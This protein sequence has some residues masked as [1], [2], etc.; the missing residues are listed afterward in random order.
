MN[1]NYADPSIASGHYQY[2]EKDIALMRELGLKAYR[3]SISWP[4]ILPD[5]RGKINQ[6]GVD[7]YR[8][9]INK[10]KE[11]EIE[12][13]VTIYHFDLPQCLQEEYGAGHPEKSSM[14]LKHI[15]RCFSHILMM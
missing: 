5:G 11:Y 10:L 13:I 1:K 7:F 6:E 15:V 4:R 12:P 14:I 9:L 3:F 2:W 8:K